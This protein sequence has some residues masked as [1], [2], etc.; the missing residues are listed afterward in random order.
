MPGVGVEP[1]APPAEAAAGLTPRR[2]TPSRVSAKRSW[3]P[4]CGR[5]PALEKGADGA[6]TVLGGRADEEKGCGGRSDVGQEVAVNGD[7]V[8]GM[9]NRT[10]GSELVQRKENGIAV[11][12]STTKR[13]LN[14]PPKKRAVSAVRKFPPG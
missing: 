10:G 9:G 2:L 7:S 1:P 14:P 12:G 5:S 11:A 6:S 3:P 13:G 8:T 4:G